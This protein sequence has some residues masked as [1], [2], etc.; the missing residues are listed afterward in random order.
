MA[1]AFGA[2]SCL[3]GMAADPGSYL[4]IDAGV[5]IVNDIDFDAF[6]GSASLELDPGFRASVAA[7]CRFTPVIAAE[8][9]TGFLFNSVDEISGPGGTLS[10][11]DSGFSQ[12]PILANVIFRFENQSP[13][14]LFA[15]AGAGGVVSSLSVD[16]AGAD[17]SDSD[18]VFA[19]QLQA[20]AHYKISD[21]VSLGLSYK[22]LGTDGPGLD[23]EGVEFDVDSVHNHA[24]MGSFN[25]AF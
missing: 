3:Q 24:I 8:V 16:D 22:Y 5:N 18:F 2:A 15:G 13:F 19:W 6:G 14:V 7:G 10:L 25:W 21:T 12:V 23:I 20:G 4:R 9:E 11:S 17:D 1:G